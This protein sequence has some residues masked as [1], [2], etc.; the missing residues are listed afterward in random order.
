MEKRKPYSFYLAQIIEIHAATLQDFLDAL[1]QIF[2]EY[3]PT[4]IS[5]LSAEI[6]HPDNLELIT[7]TS[8]DRTTKAKVEEE[9]AR[10]TIFIEIGI[11]YLSIH[12]ASPIP[13]HAVIRSSIK[14]L[15]ARLKSNML[16]VDSGSWTGR[17]SGGS[18]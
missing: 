7:S 9:R 5:L 13:T 8:D 17:P 4:S 3:G 1:A 18:F 16:F 2:K 15:E 6:L 11:F 12:S 10:A 14:T